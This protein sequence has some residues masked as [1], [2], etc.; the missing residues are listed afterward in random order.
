MKVLITG[1]A[2]FIGSHLTRRLL[3]RGDKVRGLLVAGEPDRGLEAA[4]LEVVR[5]DLTMP[6]S[7]VG[8]AE[9]CDKVIHAAMRVIDW[10]RKKDFFD[11]GVEGTRNLLEECAGMVERFVYMSSI[12]AYGFGPHLKG[13]DEYIPL[14]K[15]GLHYGDAKAEAEQI[16]GSY[17]AMGEMSA[18]VIRPANVTGPGSVWVREILDVMSKGPLPLMDGGKWSASMVFVDNLVDGIIAAMDSDTAAGRT[19]NLRD[20]YDVTWKEYISWLGGLIGK[21]PTG[22]LPY[23]AA[24]R[25]GWIVQTAFLPLGVR[26]PITSQAVG[27]MGRDNDVSNRRAKEELAWKTRVPWEEARGIIEKWVRD[28]YNPPK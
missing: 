27:I 1:A 11:L 19:Y 17:A 5:G 6:A 23:K 21:K 18:T 7:I 20:D 13:Y 28:E 8:V 2:G 24:W 9:G 22:S 12:A 26:P 15:T 16:V 4:G 3:E 14:V 10:G 25:L